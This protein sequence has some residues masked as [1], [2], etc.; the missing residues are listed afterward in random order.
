MALLLLL[1][2]ALASARGRRRLR[3]VLVVIALAIAY[4]GAV[5]PVG[6]VLLLPLESQYAPLAAGQPLPPVSYVVV[7]GSGYEPHDNVP[8]T[9]A[10]DEDGLVRIAEGVRLMKVL[11]TA[12]LLVSGGAPPGL[13]VPAHGYARFARE[14]GVPQSSVV[15]LDTE[16]DTA[17][18]ARAI[19]AKLAGTP[20]LLVTSAWHMPRAMK[21]MKQFGAHAIAAPTG[22]LTGRPWAW[23]SWVPNADGLKRTERAIH[24]Y[25]GLAALALCV[26]D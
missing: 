24:E 25:F 12:R 8:V 19:A 1:L 14:L 9:A 26:G 16:L 2:S 13:G 17:Q 11:G 10:L 22:Q 4:L 7:L 5:I 21:L 20:F 18:E 6:D 15:I 23:S 3:T